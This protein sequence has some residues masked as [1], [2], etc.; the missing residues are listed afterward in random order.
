MNDVSDKKL[1]IVDRGPYSYLAQSLSLYYQKVYYHCIP[2]GGPYEESPITHIGEGLPGVEWIRSFWPYLDKVD[3]VFFP[4]VHQGKMQI[5]L[6]KLGV[7]V[8]GSMGGE[9]MELDKSFFLETLKDVGLPVVAT[10]RCFGI[11]ELWEYVKDKEG[12]LYMKN[13]D[14]ERGDWETTPHINKYQTK[15]FLDKKRQTLGARADEIVILVQ[16]AI[17][18]ACE[19][20]IDTFRLNGQIPSK[21]CGGYEIKDEGIIET[22]FDSL[23]E[24]AEAIEKK[25]GPEYEKLGYQGPYSN[26][27]RITEW[28]KV[29]TIDETCRC[30]SPPT[31]SLCVLLGEEYAQSV[32]ELAHDV[33]P[34]FKAKKGYVAEI[35]LSSKWHME[36][37]LHI[38]A[39]KDVEKAGLFVKNSICQ[40]GQIYA[41]PNGDEGTFGSI[42]SDKHPNYAAAINDVMER[43]GNLQIY[44]LDYDKNVFDASKEKIDAGRAF[45]IDF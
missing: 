10:H 9:K 12:P 21:V 33:L 28:G 25:L 30:A 1:L 8:C 2:A 35:I 37:E 27:M 16:A 13:A 38:G 20:G 5:A 31:P 43:V 34:E 7:P 42:T 32:Y 18:A 45:N 15:K 3:A 36:N 39:A 41:I 29:Y 14:P 40:D 17:E 44:Q 6:K 4:D 23:P 19:F 11:D 22:I 24:P 26:E